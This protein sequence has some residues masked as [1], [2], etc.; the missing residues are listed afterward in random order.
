M[1]DENQTPQ[2]LPPSL[3]E[4]QARPRRRFSLKLPDGAGFAAFLE[5]G[6]LVVRR[7]GLGFWG[8]LATLGLCAFFLADIL[9]L[10]AGN[11]LTRFFPPT[12]A[13]G[14]R[15]SRDA[16]DVVRQ[17]P[18]EEYNI[19]FSRNLFNSDGK[20]PGEDA[21]EGVKDMGGAP[22]KTNL[23][24]NLVGTLILRDELK[25]IATIEDRSASL[26]YPVRIDDE[27]PAKAKILKIEARKVIFINTATGRREFID[28]PEDGV[29]L[30]AQLGSARTTPLKAAAGTG[31][32]QVS[33]TQFNISRTEIDK[34][35]SDFNNILTQARAV[36]N[37]KNGQ[38]YGYKLFQIVPG[39]IYSKLGMR[40]GDAIVGADGQTL[41]DPGKA[42]EMLNNLKTKDRLELKVERDGKL[43]DFSY[44]IR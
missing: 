37:M 40:D 44:D 21:I 41:N 23:P 6:L 11:S 34:V 33:T 7:R 15:P 16:G 3:D 9:A 38:P 32:E 30:G 17:K 8:T 14:F 22:V 36:P 28:L 20:I 39:S 12:A 43:V 25:S 1:N 2:Q 42:F 5:N 24:F 19:I 13:R 29:A 27:I 31:I 26:V 18:I 35:F 4:E 10:I